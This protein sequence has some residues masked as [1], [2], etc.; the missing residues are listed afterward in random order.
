MALSE[1]R[2][3]VRTGELIAQNRFL[4][5]QVDRIGNKLAGVE[6]SMDSLA[7]EDG[8]LR[9]TVDLPSLDEEIRLVGIGSILPAEGAILG[10]EQLD[11]LLIRLDEIE[12]KISVQQQS[13]FEI[14]SKI[15]DDEKRLRNIPAIIPVKTGRLN[16]NYGY[17]SDPFTK[18]RRFHYGQDFT[19][20]RGTPVYA[21]ADGKVIEVRRKALI[22]KVIKI[23]HGYG[24]ETLFGHLNGFEVRKGQKIK[25]GDLIGYVGNT[26]RSTGSHLHYE[27]RVE[28]KPVDP[29]D[30]FYEGYDFVMNR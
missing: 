16:D 18:V 19:A 7:F 8:L 20:P 11:G 28:G 5:E 29:L 21:T 24:Y 12:R 14:E 27:V 9:A 1:W 15:S 26:G 30:Y 22:G 2:V 10:D 4:G 13:Y 17:R 23:D 6:R 25:R 3:H